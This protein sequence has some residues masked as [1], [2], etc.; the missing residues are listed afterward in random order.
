MDL[1]DGLPWGPEESWACRPP[2]LMK[3]TLSPVT[4]VH[5]TTTFSFVIPRS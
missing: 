4:T 5:G 2:K 1:T 3:N